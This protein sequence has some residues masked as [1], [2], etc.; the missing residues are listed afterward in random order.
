MCSP[1]ISQWCDTA[2]LH[3]KGT[4][5]SDRSVC[6][7]QAALSQASLGTPELQT[8]GQVHTSLKESPGS[9]HLEECTGADTLQQT[10]AA[11][12]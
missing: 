8:A 10:I 9:Q 11:N 1:S 12:T 3:S 4:V 5:E 7:I 6:T 2:G